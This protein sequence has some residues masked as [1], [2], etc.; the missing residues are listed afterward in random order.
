M[1]GGGGRGVVPPPPQNQ[2]SLN[3]GPDPPPLVV[4]EGEP[5]RGNLGETKVS[6]M[7]RLPSKEVVLERNIPIG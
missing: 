6:G 4:K 1:T 3:T 5:P 7:N 2:R